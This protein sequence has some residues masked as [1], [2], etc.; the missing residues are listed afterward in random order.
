[1]RKQYNS[2]EFDITVVH[3]ESI[4]EEEGRASDPQIPVIVIDPGEER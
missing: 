3:F 2:P 4:L 1:M